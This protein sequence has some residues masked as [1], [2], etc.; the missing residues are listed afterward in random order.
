MATGTE[1]KVY[2]GVWNRQHMGGTIIQVEAEHHRL[3]FDFGFIYDPGR[4]LLER[5]IRERPLPLPDLIRRGILPPVEGVFPSRYLGEQLSLGE[6]VL[7]YEA[8]SGEKKMMVAISHLHLDHMAGMGWVAPEIPVLLSQPSARFYDILAEVGEGVG[9]VRPYR[10]VPYEEVIHHGPIRFSFVPIDHD[11]PGAAGLFIETPEV[12][13]VYTGDFRCHGARR[14]VTQE[15]FEKVRAFRPH[16][17]F[18]EGTTLSS[19]EELPEEDLTR[20]DP[21]D[22]PFQT[23]GEVA[24]ELAKAFSHR[25]LAVVNLYLRNADRLRSVLQ[26]AEE[27]GRMVL[28]EPEWSWVYHRWWG[29]WLPIYVAR[30]D[31]P[32]TALPPEVWQR[33]WFQEVF[34]KAPRVGAKDVRYE[35]HR[36]LIQNSFENF[37]SLLDLPTEGGIYI[38]SGGTPLGAFDPRY[39]HLLQL[40]RSLGMEYRLLGN[41]G[42]AAPSHL[43]K[44]LAMAQPKVLVPIHSRYPERLAVRARRSFLPAHGVTYRVQAKEL[45]QMGR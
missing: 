24:E 23:E 28:V 15:F 6:E 16:L 17:L 35:P 13:M 7:P 31:A 20:P 29:F 26:A 27:A 41:H 21:L 25:G 38:H 18:M 43:L 2:R 4:A 12:R 11:V 32:E 34:A 37:W 10:G 40:V 1:L 39:P 45:S 19:P 3:L 5:D 33:P 30:P 42:H 22:P 14:Q 9:P 8:L 36:F 44:V